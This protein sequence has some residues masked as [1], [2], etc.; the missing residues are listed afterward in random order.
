MFSLLCCA[1]IAQHNGLYLTMFA[2]GF[3]STG[4]LLRH[5]GNCFQCGK[6]F[7]SVFVS[8]IDNKVKK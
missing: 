5:M 6:N 4:N 1:I 7:V 8:V 3:Q 2:T